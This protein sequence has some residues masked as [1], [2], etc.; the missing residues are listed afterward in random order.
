[1]LAMTILMIISFGLM[2]TISILSFLSFNI[3]LV[4]IF[5]CGFTLGVSLM[6][7]TAGNNI[8]A[9]SLTE[10]EKGIGFG[11]LFTIRSLVFVISPFGFASL[12]SLSKDIG[13]PSLVFGVGIVMCCVAL[14]TAIFVLRP[15]LNYAE[16]N[17]IVYKYDNHDKEKKLIQNGNG[18]DISGQDSLGYVQTKEDDNYT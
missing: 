10:S 5:I 17:G 11:I 18:Y 1:M 13:Y 12:Y 2:M 14:I 16:K 9:T 4:I 8:A 15:K 7:V 3:K 6:V